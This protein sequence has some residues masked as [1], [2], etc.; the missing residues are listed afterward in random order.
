MTLL[1]LDHLALSAS[2]LAEGAS[3]VE[4]ALGLR[5]SPG[6]EHAAMGTH[7]KLLGLGDEIY[8]EVI[9]INPDAQGPD[10]PR[11]FNID[12]FSGPPRLTNWIL[13]TPDLARALDLL[14][15]DFGTPMRLS[16]GD[17]SW[18]MAVPDDGILPWGGWGPALI[19][20]HGGAHP[21]TR[22]P[23]QGARLSALLIR[24]PDAAAMAQRLGP[25]MPR[26]TAM[27][28]PA[29]TPGIVASLETPQGARILR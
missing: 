18:S 5:L 28:E 14:G 13:R 11:W 16:R 27:F 2:S 22:L 25:H 4:S 19:E 26:D 3:H 21:A 24:H 15:H 10:R 17:L 7:N 1:T 23:D 20:W 12:A 9:A 6:G 8:F 29:E